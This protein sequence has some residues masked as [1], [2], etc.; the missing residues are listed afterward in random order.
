MSNTSQVLKHLKDL[1]HLPLEGLRFRL[2]DA[3]G[4]IVGHLA[5]QIA[6]ILQGKD[7]PIYNPKKNLG[8]V[9]VVINAAHVHFTHD[10]WNTKLYR[11]HTGLPGGLKERKAIDQWDRDPTK[12]LK[13]AVKGML[14][15]NKTQ[16][17]RMEKLKVFPELDHPFSDFDLVPYIPTSKPFQI[18]QIGWSIPEGMEAVNVEKHAFR[19]KASSSL[20]NDPRPIIDFSDLMTADERQ[21]LLGQ[22]QKTD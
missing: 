6:I 2:V 12:I 11:W 20:K 9:V 18:P 13:D 3:K 8:D 1:K 14:P 7:K 5:S 10:T 22:Q 17:Y 21:L 4:Q 15:K 19:M 16:V